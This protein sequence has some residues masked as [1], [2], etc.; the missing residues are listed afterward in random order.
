LLSLL[1]NNCAICDEKGQT[2]FHKLAQCGNLKLMIE[3]LEKQEF[4]KQNLDSKNWYYGSVH[5]TL[6]DFPQKVKDIRKLPVII[7]VISQN[8]TI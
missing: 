5:G 2:P 7:C 1:K 6:I 8:R 3:E 4:K